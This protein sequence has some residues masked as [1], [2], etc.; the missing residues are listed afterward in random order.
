MK[1]LL[2]YPYFLT[3]RGKD[4]DV[5][6]LPIGLHYIG[7][8][9]IEAGHEVEILNL[10]GLMGN[11]EKLR[12]IFEERDFDCLGVSLFNGN[13]FGA[14][15]CAKIAKEINPNTKVIFGG[16]GAT[17]LWDFF[18][19][20]FDFVD[21]IVRGEGEE[22]FKEL[23]DT[24]EKG[25]DQESF[26]SI[27]GLGLRD[28]KGRPVKTQER[29]FIKELD[30]LPDPSRYFKFQ[31][32]ISSRGCPWNCTFCG[33]PRF[34]KRRVRFHSPKYFVDQL[35]RLHKKGV[36]F[37]YVSDD[38]FTLNKDRVIEICQEILERGL[39]ISWYAISRVNCVDEDIVYW[40][41][42]A[43]CIQISYGVESGSTAVRDFFNKQ[44]S[45]DDIRK[46]FHITRR[47]GI[48]PRAY[49]IYGAPGDGKRSIQESID[50][51]RDIKPLSMVSY[52]L[53]LYP[54]TKLYDNFVKKNRITNDIWLEPI[55]D[56]MY[57]ETDPKMNSEEVLQ[58]GRRLKKAFYSMLPTF[59]ED[60]E[61]E[62]KDELK[63]HY[64]AFC[65]RL[66]FTFTHG[67]YAQN[68]LI[69]NKEMTAERL[70]KKALKWW[71]NHDAFLGLGMLYQKRREF[72]NSIEILKQ[73][74]KLYGD[75]E[76]LNICLGINLMNLGQFKEA[77]AIFKRFPSSPRAKRY[78][79]IC[80]SK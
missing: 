11:L 36:N 53:D 24:I 34:W 66:G 22:T 55:E 72:D 73:G 10:H 18:L 79:E 56:I 37:F 58:M 27:N 77:M 9:L 70:F 67:D 35:E 78:Y 40:M 47:F 14:L 23:L 41:K 29:P 71:P 49:F 69:P 61:F 7:A 68:D 76:E 6:P 15:D 17:F 31:H 44:I 45:D 16:V 57:F 46:A 60:L 75:S 33:S 64:A 5:R 43:G 13:R 12:P 1:V 51:I 52:I 62:E 80:A 59:I 21:F 30:S 4:Y 74:L 8:Y 54:G 63:E 2:V 38:T 42:R 26:F 20:H 32:V 50:L 3:E 28:M 39:N 25:G 48:L 19:R 65:A